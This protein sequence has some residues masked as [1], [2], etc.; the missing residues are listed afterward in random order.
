[1]TPEQDDEFLDLI[2]EADSETQYQRFLVQWARK[3]E[4][5]PLLGLEEGDQWLRRR[6]NRRTDYT[7]M[8]GISKR[9]YRKDLPWTW[10]EERVMTWAFLRD[11]KESKQE[12][13]EQYIASL[14]QRT[15]DEVVNK[16]FK[17]QNTKRGH[18]GFDI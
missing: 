15:V 18:V 14:L 1:M 4:R 2:L 10:T 13:T 6:A 11:H 17:M 9:G 12:V 5:D 7:Y 3:L 16:L 8:P